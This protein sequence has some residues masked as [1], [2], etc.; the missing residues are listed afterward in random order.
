MKIRGR[1]IK[2]ASFVCLV[3]YY[4]IAYW[5]PGSYSAIGGVFQDALGLSCVST[6]SSIVAAM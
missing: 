2:A 1:K 5:L 6:Y 3:L 4:G